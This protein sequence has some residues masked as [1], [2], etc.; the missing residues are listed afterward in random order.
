MTGN[1]LPFS[2]DNE[3]NTFRNG[4]N[5]GH[6]LENVTCKKSLTVMIDIRPIAK[7]EL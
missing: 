7:P 5:I 6:K 4:G 2:D 3:R 1:F